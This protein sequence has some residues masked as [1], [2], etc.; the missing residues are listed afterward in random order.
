MAISTMERGK[1]KAEPGSAGKDGRA[2][3]LNGVFK[4]GLTDQVNFED[5]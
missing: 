4:E 2:A 1:Q 3:V 5:F